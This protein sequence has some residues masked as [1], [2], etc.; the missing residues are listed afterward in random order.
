MASARNGSAPAEELI[1]ATHADI[2][3]GGDRAYYRRPTPEGSFPNHRE[4]DFKVLPPRTTFDPAAAFYET[5]VHELVHWTEPRLG[6][7]GTYAMGELVAEIASCY[8][9]AELGIPQGEGLG[10]HASN[11]RHW[12]DAMKGDRNYIFKAAKHAST[13]TDFLL[14]FVRKPE[15]VSAATG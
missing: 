8:I 14:G 10:N 12:L 15:P 11:V 4:G 2:R 1:A 5:G 3:F 9:T 7:C 13:A 6:F